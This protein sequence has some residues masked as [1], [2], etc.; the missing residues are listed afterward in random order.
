[1]SIYFAVRNEIRQYVPSR[2]SLRVVYVET[3]GDITSLEVDVTREMIYYTIRGNTT[4]QQ[5]GIANGYRKS[6]SNVGVAKPIALDWITQNVYFASEAPSTEGISS[7]LRVCNVAGWHCALISEPIHS[8]TAL[9]VDAMNKYLF[10]ATVL[11]NLEGGYNHIGPIIRLYRNNLS[12]RQSNHIIKTFDNAINNIAIDYRHKYVYV[13]REGTIDRLDYD[14][15]RLLN[16]VETVM[17]TQGLNVFENHLYFLT[18]SGLTMHKCRLYGD[19]RRCTSFR[20]SAD[21]TEMFVIAQKSRQT[22]GR[23]ACANYD[24]SHLCLPNEVGASCVCRNGDVIEEALD[25]TNVV[26]SIE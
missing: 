6:V 23:N 26:L 3:S 24:C 12:S 9:A 13:A 15:N 11:P 20:L 21:I 18:E 1:M 16:I 14:G 10:Y 17:R 22:P 25:C 4:L 2:R 7:Q 5:L 8:V 19:A